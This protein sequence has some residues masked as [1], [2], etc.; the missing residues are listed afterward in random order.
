MK[1]DQHYL[2]N[3]QAKYYIGLSDDVARRLTQHNTGVSAW[4]P[5]RGPWSLVWT[6]DHMSLSAARKLENLLKR[7]KGGHGFYKIT[8]LARSLVS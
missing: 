1:A 3:A 4:T 2:E 8:G 7:Q 6:S 5:S